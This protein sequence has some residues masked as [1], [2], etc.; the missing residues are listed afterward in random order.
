MVVTNEK[1]R[2]FARRSGISRVAPFRRKS[3]CTGGTR[4]CAERRQTEC[5]LDHVSNN[6]QAGP[7][8]NEER[9]PGWRDRATL[10]SFPIRIR[11]SVRWQRTDPAD[12]NVG[13]ERGG[14]R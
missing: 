8:I 10:S 7:N 12:R 1:H 14:L 3:V 2:D 6:M 13:R 9:M 5:L 4:P 11:R